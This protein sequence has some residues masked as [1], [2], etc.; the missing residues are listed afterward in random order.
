MPAL[1][2]ILETFYYID[3]HPGVAILHIE[4]TRYL[5]NKGVTVFI[6]VVYDLL[7]ARF[8]H[9]FWPELWDEFVEWLKALSHANGAI[10]ISR[11]VALN[12]SN[13]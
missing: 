13:G 6:S 7:P 12:F 8:P 3:L 1:N 5:R 4:K 11:A 2:F 10:C 9:F